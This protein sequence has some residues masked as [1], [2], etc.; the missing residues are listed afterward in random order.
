MNNYDAKHAY[1]EPAEAAAYDVKRFMS[2]RGQI[3]DVLDKQALSKALAE[4]LRSQSRP[5]RILDIPCGTGR[6]TR[7]LLKQEHY[8]I[9]ADVSKEMMEVA[10]TKVADFAAFGGFYQSDA[11]SLS[12]QDDSFDC[13]VSVRFMGHIPSNVRAR[14]LTEFHRLSQHAIIEYTVK[15]R[16]A[17]LRRRVERYLKTGLSLPQRWPWH[18]F[19]KQELYGE[20][21][22]AGFHV[23][24]MWPKIRYLSDSWYVLV[25]RR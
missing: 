19:E 23:V 11:A 4:L 14:I 21:R 10:Q 3:G 2:L 7:F 24:G 9:G 17:M 20:L 6:M 18:V 1:Q 16:V 5:L 15:S 8:V 12:F 25:Q 13:V 22:A